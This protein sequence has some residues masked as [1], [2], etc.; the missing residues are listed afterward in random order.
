MKENSVVSVTIGNLSGRVVFVGTGR[1]EKEV[2][3]KKGKAYRVSCDDGK[4]REV[5]VG[6][7]SYKY[8]SIMTL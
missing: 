7:P 2:A 4:T 5:S 6:N 1:I 8:D 3:S